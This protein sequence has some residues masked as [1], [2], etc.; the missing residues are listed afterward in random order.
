MEM[1]AATSALAAL[2]HPTRLSIFRRLIEAG[3]DGQLAGELA[4]AL[5][6]PGATLSFHLKTLR[7]AGLVTA[8]PCGRHVRYR[9]QL[10]TVQALIDFLTRDCCRHSGEPNCLTAMATCQ[11]RC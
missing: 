1:N 9:P 8:E 10:P 11:A 2:G 4:Q 5:S 3:P 7:A 6:L